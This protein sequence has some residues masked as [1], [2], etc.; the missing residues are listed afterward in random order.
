MLVVQP[1]LDL[2][3]SERRSLHKL[4]NTDLSDRRL[5]GSLFADGIHRNIKS[6]HHTKASTPG[7]EG[8]NSTVAAV[9]GTPDTPGL[10]GPLHTGQHATDMP[11]PTPQAADTRRTR[12]DSGKDHTYDPTEEA[13]NWL[14]VGVGGPDKDMIPEIEVIAESP[15]AADFNIYDA[16]YENEVRRIQN[17]QGH[18]ATI[19]RTRRVDSKMDENISS[20]P[21][22]SG[23]AGNLHGGLA[24]APDAAQG[25]EGGV[26]VAIQ[27]RGEHAHRRP[28]VSLAGQ[29]EGV[30]GME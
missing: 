20:E 4:Q 18:Q 7:G 13:P 21:S 28:L 30:R 1:P 24:D 27:D 10:P 19:Y 2:N 23:A 14:G 6:T 15:S 9:P 8:I 22:G 29:G 17:A 16:A 11:S 3:S 25:K 12:N 26:T 5:R